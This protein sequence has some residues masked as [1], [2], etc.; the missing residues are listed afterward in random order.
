MKTKP[1]IDQ[2]P[3]ALVLEHDDNHEEEDEAAKPGETSNQ[4]WRRLANSR[5]RSL[6]TAMERMATL[7]ASHHEFTPD[8]MQTLIEA[9][10]NKF[11]QMAK[12]LRN[13]GE[14]IFS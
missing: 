8:E 4:R 5:G 12:K 6:F 13:G 1:K 14:D 2:T 9:C 3:H 7:S 10:I 11:D